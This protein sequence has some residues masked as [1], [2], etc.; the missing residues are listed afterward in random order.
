[1]EFS[2]AGNVVDQK[3]KMMQFIETCG[4][5]IPVRMANYLRVD[6]II[7]SA[8]LSELLSEKRLVLSHMRVGNSPIYFMKGQEFKLEN[9]SQYLSSKEREAFEMLK[10]NSVLDDEKML[11]AIRVALRAI[12]DFAF[13]FNCNGKTYWRYLKVNEDKAVELINSGLTV[14]KQISEQISVQKPAFLIQR[15]I[16]TNYQ[17]EVAVK[18]EGIE[19]EKKQAEFVSPFDA[20][21]K[22]KEKSEFIQELEIKPIIKV[23]RKARAKPKS[24]FEIKINKFIEESKLEISEN[25]KNKKKEI[26]GVI[27]FNGREHLFIAKDKKIINESDI[28]SLLKSGKKMKLPIL[29]VSEGEPN[30]KAIEGIDYFKSLISYRKLA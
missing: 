22:D 15:G 29:L 24:N 11:P 13:S 5:T 21:A 12:K 19:V 1:M 28:N 26:I 27:R 8:M 6:S 23:I 2:N 14:L 10:D 4:P 3:E 7:V 16:E 20:G 30:K 18:H 17:G 25:L 9:F